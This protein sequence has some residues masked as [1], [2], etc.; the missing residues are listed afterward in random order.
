[1][2]NE[3]AILTANTSKLDGIIAGLG[4]LLSQL[5]TAQAENTSK[6]AGLENDASE[7]RKNIKAENV[8]SQFSNPILNVASIQGI[9]DEYIRMTGEFDAATAALAN[10]I[11]SSRNGLA[12][13]TQDAATVTREIEACIER[14]NTDADAMV[15]EATRLEAELTR[16]EAEC[17]Q[18]IDALETIANAKT[19]NPD[20]KLRIDALTVAHST[21]N[22][23]LQAIVTSHVPNTNVTGY[24]TGLAGAGAGAGELNALSKLATDSIK[25]LTKQNRD[26]DEMLAELNSPNYQTAD[27][28]KEIESDKAEA[29]ARK[30]EEERA[31][32][33]ASDKAAEDKAVVEL[34]DMESVS[35]Y[36]P[37][38]VPKR[39]Q[40]PPAAAPQAGKQSD[41]SSQSDPLELEEVEPETI[42]EFVVKRPAVPGAAAAGSLG[43]SIRHRGKRHV[44][45]RGGLGEGGPIVL[46]VTRLTPEVRTLLL[47][48]NP[49]N[50]VL[51]PELFRGIIKDVTPMSRE[52]AEAEYKKISGALISSSNTGR[53]IDILGQKV[54]WKTSIIK[55]MIFLDS[56]NVRTSQSGLSYSVMY[57]KLWTFMERDSG[58]IAK[59]REIFRDKK[60]GDKTLESVLLGS[61]KL[62]DILE[63]VGWLAPT[64]NTLFDNLFKVFSD[65]NKAE[66]QK[67]MTSTFLTERTSTKANNMYRF[68]LNWLILIA[69]NIYH[70]ANQRQLLT[71]ICEFVENLY[72]IFVGWM[73]DMDAKSLDGEFMPKTTQ[74][75]TY[76]MKTNSLITSE[77]T[78]GSLTRLREAIRYKLCEFGPI[79][80]RISAAKAAKEAKAAA[81]LPAS[82]AASSRSSSPAPAPAQ[83]SS[84][85]ASPESRPISSGNTKPLVMKAIGLQPQPPPTTSPLIR[86]INDPPPKTQAEQKAVDVE[87]VAEEARKRFAAEDA[88]EAKAAEAAAAAARL[89]RGFAVAKNNDWKKDPFM[90]KEDHPGYEKLAAVAAAAKQEKQTERE[91]RFVPVGPS[92]ESIERGKSAALIRQATKPTKPTKPTSARRGGNKQRTRKRHRVASTHHHTKRRI[93][94]NKNHKHTRKAR[95]VRASGSV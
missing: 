82:S 20:L 5:R 60:I 41:S 15:A 69:F 81:K 70:T 53:Y 26:L 39:Q 80:E 50:Q 86:R 33:A 73:I 68:K 2:C 48:F 12:Q 45:Q 92:D 77:S 94:R 91:S 57:D 40:A 14:R 24:Q 43:G 62:G 88:A 17:K 42:L 7:I 93:L 89:S 90:Y 27:I 87:A 1:M 30:A 11:S 32:A 28:Q 23:Q 47:N 52:D 8:T 31:A 4:V 51:T 29:D 18:R 10:S 54:A 67:P 36:L 64:K 6:L 79:K 74:G 75:E 56:N 46:R 55:L 25:T 35:I 95:Q 85:S 44:L 13:Y 37:T 3:Q 9:R 63:R 78:D 83:A 34:A 71:H 61:G 76:I 38:T 16:K 84:R 66:G 49:L 59:L 22:V 65:C 58:S 19:E 21:F 72:N